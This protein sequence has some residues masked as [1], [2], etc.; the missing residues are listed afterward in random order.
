MQ[1]LEMDEAGKTYTIT[2][3]GVGEY[4]FDYYCNSL[5]RDGYKRR[6]KREEKGVLSAVFS[7]PLNEVTVKLFRKDERLTITVH[8][9]GENV[10]IY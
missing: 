2:A 3:L 7:S 10:L 6:D 4:N 5:K 8:P 1:T 9:A